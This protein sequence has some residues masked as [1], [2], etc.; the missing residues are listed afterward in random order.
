MPRSDAGPSRGTAAPTGASR[1]HR[2]DV[3]TLRV[4][5]PPRSL[6]AVWPDEVDGADIEAEERAVA[7]LRCGDLELERCVG[8]EVLDQP[9][10]LG[11]VEPFGEQPQVADVGRERRT[12]G[13]EQRAGRSGESIDADERRAD[14]RPD[15]GQPRDEAL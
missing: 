14:R 3:T 9:A 13:V 4:V 2:V 10:A 11:G 6:C 12:G 8:E 1:H 7:R 15:A 5:E